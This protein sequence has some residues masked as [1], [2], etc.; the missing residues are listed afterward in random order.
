MQKIMV[1]S[2][3]HDDRDAI[4]VVMRYLK[5]IQVDRIIHL[6]DYYD[7]ADV[8]EQAG[9]P[10]TRVPGTWDTVYYPDPEVSNRMFIEIAGW[11]IFLTHT[12]ESHYNDRADDIK[13]ESIIGSE[14]ADIFLF[15]HTHIAEIRRRNGTVCINPGHMSSDE[16]RGCPLTFALLEIDPDQIKVSIFQLPEP[17]PRIQ[18]IYKKSDLQR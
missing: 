9:Y 8:L 10:L 1:I 14:K 6:G 12:P 17:H 4:R 16:S 3:T 15:G 2:D 11:R 5:G 13:P 7:D 18:K